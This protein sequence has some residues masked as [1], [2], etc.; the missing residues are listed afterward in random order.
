MLL[1][2]FRPNFNSYWFSGYES[3]LRSRA[4]NLLVHC[5]WMEL[6]VLACDEDGESRPSIPVPPQGHRVPAF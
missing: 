1:P 3:I 2:Q 6:A 4:R 5:T